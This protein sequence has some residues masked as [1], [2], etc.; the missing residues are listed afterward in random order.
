MVLNKDFALPKFTNLL[1]QKKVKNYK[2]ML[3][4]VYIA[5]LAISKCL[6]TILD[7]LFQ[8]PE[9]DQTSNLFILYLVLGCDF[10]IFLF[11]LTTELKHQYILYLLFLCISQNQSNFGV[12]PILL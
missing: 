1:I 3:K 6:K 5:K 2:S 9:E 11:H 7:G 8:R 10:I 12:R 4:I